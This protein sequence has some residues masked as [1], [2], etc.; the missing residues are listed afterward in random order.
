MKLADNETLCKQV[1]F[2]RVAIYSISFV[3]VSIYAN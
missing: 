1:L 3:T 2:Y